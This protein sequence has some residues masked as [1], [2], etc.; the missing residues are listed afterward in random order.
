MEAA[1]MLNVDFHTISR[2]ENNETW[3]LPQSITKI[4]EFLGDAS[5]DEISKMSLGERI[6]ISQDSQFDPTAVS[7]AARCN[8][9]DNK[10]LGAKYK[11]AQKEA[12][13]KA[14]GNIGL[15]ISR[16]AMTEEAPERD[17]KGGVKHIVA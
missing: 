13:E 15:A 7:K 3:P 4:R 5:S 10:L 14:Q 8:R 9:N 1:R 12:T 16:A 11:Q 2:W 6:F 17:V